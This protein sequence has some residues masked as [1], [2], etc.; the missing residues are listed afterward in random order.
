[1]HEWE[2]EDAERDAWLAE[3]KAEWKQEWVEMKRD[4]AATAAWKAKRSACEE[5]DIADDNA[6]TGPKNVV[7]ENVL[8]KARD[9]NI[10]LGV[11]HVNETVEG[12]MPGLRDFFEAA[13]QRVTALLERGSCTINGEWLMYERLRDIA[14]S[15]SFNQIMMK[16]TGQ[17]YPLASSELINMYPYLQVQAFLLRDAVV[18]AQDEESEDAEFESDEETYK[19]NS[20]E[21][22]DVTVEWRSGQWHRVDTTSW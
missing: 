21:W 8:I 1:M 17:A 4:E 6:G 10:M 22:D 13:L 16:S 20:C 3:C 11:I 19:G 5:Q 18:S 14:M 9:L 7:D 15:V 2:T 12:S